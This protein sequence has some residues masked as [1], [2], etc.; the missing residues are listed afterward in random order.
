MHAYGPQGSAKF[1]T[2]LAESLGSRNTFGRQ[3]G[4]D[5]PR[6]AT[7]FDDGT[8]THKILKKPAATTL[9]ASEQIKIENARQKALKVGEP[10]R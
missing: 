6:L 1:F 7:K 9:S 8:V 2:N 3:T 4:G 5:V 10:R